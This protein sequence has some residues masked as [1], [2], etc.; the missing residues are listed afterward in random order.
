MLTQ[1]ETS[2]PFC[3]HGPPPLLCPSCP[4]C[5]R[6]KE[7]RWW[8]VLPQIN[9]SLMTLG[10][11]MALWKFGW[12]LWLC[13]KVHDVGLG[14]T[15]LIRRKIS[16]FTDLFFFLSKSYDIGLTWQSHLIE[17][18]MT[19]QHNM[20]EILRYSMNT[21]EFISVNAQFCTWQTNNAQFKQTADASQTGFL[22]LWRLWSVRRCRWKL[23]LWRRWLFCLGVVEFG[24][25]QSIGGI[26]SWIPAW[27]G[28]CM[29]LNTNIVVK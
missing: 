25:I 15:F 11:V 13:L 20:T 6:D 24:D 23:N 14:N 4:C 17:A 3:L 28:V 26:G 12:M 22:G 9:S 27:L 2:I 21:E 1:E 5:L 8:I 19:V 29:T 16:L 18:A 7:K 10:K